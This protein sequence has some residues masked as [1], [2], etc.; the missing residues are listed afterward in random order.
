LLIEGMMDDWVAKRGLALIEPK[1]LKQLSERSDALGLLQLGS[2][3]V[4]IAVTGAVLI[5]TWGSWWAVPVFIAYGILINCLYAGQHEMSHWTA[6]KSRWLNDVVGEV[7]GFVVIYPFRWD[8]WFHFTHHRNTQNWQKDPELLI[9]G[10]Y[11]LGSYLLN[12]AGLT[13]WYGR[14]RSTLRAALGIVP[15]Y[16]Y[17]LN[18]DQRRQVVAEARWCVAGYAAIALLSASFQ[19]WLAVEL[20][21]A[22]MLLTKG[23][24]QLQNVGEHTGLTH[25]PDTLQNT[26]TLK[27]PPWLRWLMWNMSYHTAHH[28]FPGVPFHRLPALHRELEER[29]GEPL[30]SGGYLETHIGILRSVSRGVEQLELAQ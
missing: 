28:T 25:R 19:S 5:L 30:P 18:D 3:L 17:W 20:W 10:P 9:R 14:S 22:P 11:T 29:L 8:R 23:F 2:Q 1:R 6:F 13:Y 27:G 21:L 7:I 16:A 12:L 26:R 15:H 4:A 24:H